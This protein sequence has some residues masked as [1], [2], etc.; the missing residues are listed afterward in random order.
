MRIGIWFACRYT[1]GMGVDELADLET[2]KTKA[3]SVPTPEGLLKALAEHPEQLGLPQGLSQ[4]QAL[5][6][7][8]VRGARQA[9]FEQRERERQE[10]YVR[11]HSDGEWQQ[12]AREAHAEAREDELV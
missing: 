2:P 9:L 8:L 5:A 6:R 11:L 1:A 4:R 10:M 7:L 3:V 12:A